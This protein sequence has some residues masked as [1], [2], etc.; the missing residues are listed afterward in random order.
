MGSAPVRFTTVRAGI[1]RGDALPFTSGLARVAPR[2]WGAR[3]DGENATSD[4]LCPRPARVPVEAKVAKAAQWGGIEHGDRSPFH[5]RFSSRSHCN[6]G[7]ARED[8]WRQREPM[9][10][11]RRRA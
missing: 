3:I 8:R 6:S 7:R 9:R 10:S 2:A 4:A 5:E 1:E 11:A